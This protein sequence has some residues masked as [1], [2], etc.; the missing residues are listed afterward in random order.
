MNY[1]NNKYNSENMSI[2]LDLFVDTI[3]IIGLLLIITF[4]AL[5]FLRI[6]K[7]IRKK[8]LKER[9]KFKERY[10]PMCK[11]PAKYYPVKRIWFC[12]NCG[13]FKGKIS[14]QY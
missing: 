9:K 5:W 3:L 14:R 7:Y 6:F 11:S 13:K 4:L 1:L 10:C 8:Q 12:D 2:L